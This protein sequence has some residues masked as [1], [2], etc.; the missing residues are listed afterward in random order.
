MASIINS[1]VIAFIVVLAHKSVMVASG[2]VLSKPL[3]VNAAAVETQVDATMDSASGGS[4]IG[5]DDDDDDDDDNDDDEVGA[6][7]LG[8]GGGIAELTSVDD[9]YQV[10]KSD[11]IR[12][13]E[14]ATEW[15]ELCLV[16]APRLHL[17]SQ[18]MPGSASTKWTSTRY[19]T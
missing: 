6:H 18:A 14:F 16:I 3:P 17:L 13:I 12:C 10:L 7:Y 2:N 9:T 19:W 8:P 1:V 4:Y 15:C 5:F 11:G